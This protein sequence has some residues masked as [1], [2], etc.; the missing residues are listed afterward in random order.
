MNDFSYKSEEEKHYDSKYLDNREYSYPDENELI[1]NDKVNIA[2]RRYIENTAREIIKKR[3]YGEILDY[4]CAIGEKTY[5]FSSENWK[6]SGI[7]ISSKSVHI[8]R[9]LSDKFNINAEYVVMD[10]EN[11]TFTDSRF[12]II[13]DFGTF[14]SLDMNKAIVELCRVLKPDGYLLAIE[15]LGDNPVFKLKRFLNVVFGSRTRWAANHI[16]KIKD[17]EKIRKLFNNSDI[18]YFS[19]FTP[20][21]S[22]ILRIIPHKRHYKIISY[23]EKLDSKLLKYRFFKQ[24]AF[25]AVAILSNPV[26]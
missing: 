11:L 10:C 12:D 8:A 15:T 4:G 26:K 3:Q 19:L 23:F 21:L 16:M 25:K 22:P 5:K 13:Y 14:S 7:D 1:I 17:W 18:K 2:A 6:I 24:F 20:Y 9:L